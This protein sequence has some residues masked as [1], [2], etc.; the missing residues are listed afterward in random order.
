M[1]FIAEPPN[2]SNYST[3]LLPSNAGLK[4]NYHRSFSDVPEV[5]TKK[6]QVVTC[7]GFDVLG[8]FMPAAHTSPPPG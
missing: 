1:W 3:L 5:S 8:R 6:P 2:L 7:G 4:D